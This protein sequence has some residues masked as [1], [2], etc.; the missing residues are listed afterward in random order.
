MLQFCVVII[1]YCE[2]ILYQCLRIWKIIPTNLCYLVPW[3]VQIQVCL[4]RCY[5]FHLS[6]RGAP[7]RWL[8]P[9][10]PGHD[11]TCDRLENFAKHRGRNLNVV[12]L[13]MTSMKFHYMTSWSTFTEICQTTFTFLTIWADNLT[14]DGFFHQVTLS[15]IL[16]RNTLGFLPQIFTLI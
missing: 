6:T 10:R 2:D 16:S 4:Y 14:Y 13:L 3:A 11:A 8:I 9:S 1:Y 5:S 15:Q 12:T 7:C